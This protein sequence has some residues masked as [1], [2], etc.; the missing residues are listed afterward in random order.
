MRRRKETLKSRSERAVWCS[1]VLR[2]PSRASGLQ[3][4]QGF[5]QVLPISA[6]SPDPCFGTQQQLRDLH[7][8]EPSAVAASCSA[9]CSAY[10]VAA[11]GGV[12]QGCALGRILQL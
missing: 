12:M 3:R 11:S 5:E 10:Y 7:E 8:Q 6:P 9:T 2:S 4:C 1:G